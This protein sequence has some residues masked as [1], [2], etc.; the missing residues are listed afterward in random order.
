MITVMI[1][2]PLT[3]PDTKGSSAAWRRST[4]SMAVTRKSRQSASAQWSRSFRGSAPAAP[5]DE[6]DDVF[7]SPP[8]SPPHL[9]RDGEDTTDG[10]KR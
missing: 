8:T 2:T 4:A 1:L 9:H 10:V 3:R 5:D 7:F 6:V